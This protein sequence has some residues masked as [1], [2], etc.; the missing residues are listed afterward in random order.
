MASLSFPLIKKFNLALT[1]SNFRIPTWIDKPFTPPQSRRW[2]L[3][4]CPGSK[5]FCVLWFSSVH[6]PSLS[7]VS[8]WSHLDQFS[9][10]RS[11]WSSKSMKNHLQFYLYPAYITRV[12]HPSSSPLFFGGLSDK[13]TPATSPTCSTWFCEL[14]ALLSWPTN[15]PNVPH[16]P[17][18]YNTYSVVKF[19]LRWMQYLSDDKKAN[20][21]WLLQQVMENTSSLQHMIYKHKAKRYCF[22]KWWKHIITFIVYHATPNKTRHHCC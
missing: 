9:P 1:A 6:K 20:L 14:H 21:S 19:T 18:V 5:S 22:D 7:C 4:S 3:R 16:F 15:E 17:Q 10:L 11:F 12:S 2:G 8:L 13:L